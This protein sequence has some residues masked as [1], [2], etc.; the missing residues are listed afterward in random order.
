MQKYDSKKYL[1]D[2]EHPEFVCGVEDFE[3]P[4]QPMYEMHVL[5]NHELED[6][7]PYLI[8]LQRIN[9]RYEQIIRRL[10]GKQGYE[11]IQEEDGIKV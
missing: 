10:T 1:P 4:N 2:P 6:I 9:W 7:L 11:I 8:N 5:A 3:A